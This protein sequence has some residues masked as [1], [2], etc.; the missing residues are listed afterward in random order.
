MK[1]Q[2]KEPPKQDQ[3]ELVTEEIAPAEMRSS[4]SIELN[5]LY[6]KCFII[7]NNLLEFDRSIIGMFY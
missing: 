7:D 2:E 4:S 6:I 3:E 1:T 5:G